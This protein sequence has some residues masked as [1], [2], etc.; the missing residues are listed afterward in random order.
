MCRAFDRDTSNSNNDK[1]VL[2]EGHE[3]KLSADTNLFSFLLSFSSSSSSSIYLCLTI[4]QET[5]GTADELKSSRSDH[6]SLS[7]SASSLASSSSFLRLRLRL[8]LRPFLLLQAM[9]RTKGEQR[10]KKCLHYQHTSTKIND[11]QRL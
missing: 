4:K 6:F 11:A 5:F 9:L 10:R 7:L 2:N 3:E 1:A 8:R